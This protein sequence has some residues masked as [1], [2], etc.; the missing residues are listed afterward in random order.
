MARAGALVAMILVSLVA[1]QVSIPRPTVRQNAKLR[2]DL[3]DDDR[4]STPGDANPVPADTVRSSGASTPASA[5]PLPAGMGPSIQEQIREAE[6][7]FTAATNLPS[8]DIP[9]GGGPRLITEE[10]IGDVGDAVI[11]EA[12]VTTFATDQIFLRLEA[13]QITAF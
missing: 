6:Y 4:V 11:V 7:F 3:R 5:E 8:T 1:I 10:I 2:S 12:R 13:E 9:P